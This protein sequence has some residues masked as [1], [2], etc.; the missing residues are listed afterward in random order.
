M[1]SIKH[2]I[3]SPQEKIT[4]ASY[5]VTISMKQLNLKLRVKLSFNKL[6]QGPL[7]QQAIDFTFFGRQKDFLSVLVENR[8]RSQRLSAG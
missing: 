5:N 6:I 7:I 8:D 3:A 4:P 2:N 1:I